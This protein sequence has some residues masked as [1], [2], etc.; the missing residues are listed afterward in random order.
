MEKQIAITQYK[1]SYKDQVI[2][3]VGKC[4]VDQEVIQESDLPI[5]D[6]DLQKIPEVY[7]GKS[8]FW[9]A[10]DGDKVVGTVGILDRGENVAKLRRMFVQKVYRGTGLGQKLLDTALQFAKETG[11]TKIKLNTHTN[12]KRAHHFYE[13][14]KFVLMGEKGSGCKICYQR[15]L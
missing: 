1:D 3:L 15:E 6:D 9:I 12:M 14:N 10:R 2:G 7:T 4:L 13:K 5:D 11:Y 8:R